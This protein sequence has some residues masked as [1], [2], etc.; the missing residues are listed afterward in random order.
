MYLYT[1]EYPNRNSPYFTQSPAEQ[2]PTAEM[3]IEDLFAED[4]SQT[5]K[6]EASKPSAPIKK[7]EL[8]S[9]PALHSWEE[10]MALCRIGDQFGA[11]K[12]KDLA[13]QKIRGAVAW[14]W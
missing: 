13:L 6:T 7:I 3:E 8:K 1:L 10:D 4:D 2:K 5:V 14:H 9:Q 12:L 11:D